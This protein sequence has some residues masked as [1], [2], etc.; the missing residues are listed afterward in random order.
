MFSSLKINKA[1]NILMTS[2]F[3]LLVTFNPA[4]A[5]HDRYSES[6]GPYYENQQNNKHI[7]KVHNKAWH[8]KK[9][10]HSEPRY[11][12][13]HLEFEEQHLRG[14]NT[15]YLKRA[16]KQQYPGLNLQ[17]FNLHKAMLIAKTKHGHGSAA[18]RVGHDY[19]GDRRIGG[20][21]SE[22]HESYEG[23]SSQ[24][25]LAPRSYRDHKSYRSHKQKGPWQIKL[26][27]NFKV[28]QVTLVLSYV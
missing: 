13:I 16:L 7:K 17:D 1:A 26:N 28:S 21:R 22:F 18:L 8:N 15:L 14:N 27:G 24:T 5:S 3:A 23:Y 11:K 25:F 19:T 4:I 10:R 12:V 6:N 9:H 20:M 2:V